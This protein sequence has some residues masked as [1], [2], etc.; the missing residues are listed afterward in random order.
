MKKFFVMFVALFVVLSANF[1]SAAMEYRSV[2]VTHLKNYIG[3]WY[4]TDGD[5]LL[6]ISSDYRIN[7]FKISSLGYT[8]DTVAFYKVQIT[9]GSS[10]G[11]VY[12][13][14]FG[15]YNGCHEMLVV[16]EQVALRKTKEPRYVESVGGIYLGMDQ[17]QVVA[18]YGQPSSVENNRRSSTWTYNKEGFSVTLEYGVVSDITIYSY[19]NRRFDRSGLSANSSRGDFERKYNTNVGSR[20][21]LNIGNGEVLSIRDG[22]VSLSFFTAGMVF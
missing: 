3:N 9:D 20:G 14:T 17:N 22:K 2:P 13:Q 10:Y 18:R 8:G 12:L 11:D 7:G 16:N 1:C 21:G 4:N 6:T 15:S 19:G 5:L